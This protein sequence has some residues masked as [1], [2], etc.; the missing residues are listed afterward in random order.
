MSPKTEKMMKYELFRDAA[1]LYDRL[2]DQQ[3]ATEARRNAEMVREELLYPTG[4]CFLSYR[5]SRQHEAELL[6][7]AQHDRGIP[8]WQDINNLEEFRTED[9]IRRVLDDPTTASAIL[10]LTPDVKDSDFIRDVEAPPILERVRRQDGFFAIPV[11]A[12]GLKVSQVDEILN[13]R[14]SLENL[15]GWNLREVTGDPINSDEAAKIAK[16]VL[17][18]R[19]AAIHKS[20]PDDEP[21]RVELYTRTPSPFKLGTALLLDWSERFD[22][23]LAKSG[24]WED[25][26]LPA[27]KDVVGAVQMHA[28]KR[29]VEVSGLAALPA[30]LALGYECMETRGI[31]IAWRQPTKGRD[32]QLWS[33]D[34]AREPSGFKTETI[35][36][37]PNEKNLAVLVSVAADADAAFAASRD[38]L[39]PFRA[40]VRVFKPGREKHDVTSPEQ[41]RDVAE[42]VSIAIRDARLKYRPSGIVHLFVAAPVGLA[43]MIGQKLNT[44]GPVQTYE[45]IQTDLVGH[46]HPAALL[47]PSV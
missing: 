35:T 13:P 30:A 8:T 1:H 34:V 26:L 6:I 29:A 11:R 7:A 25:H 42:S 21:L 15:S 40:V 47:K 38:D 37:G 19:I 39:E 27:L 24:A 18:R 33:L 44:L 17:N 20:L 9:E 41:A 36:G 12:G 23:R 32:D 16:L 3:R 28:A 45:H 46:Y 14:F 31:R 4:R 10:W 5:R 22:R 2:G 43:M